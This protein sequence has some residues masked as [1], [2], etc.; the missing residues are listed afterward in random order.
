MITDLFLHLNKLVWGPGTLFLFAFVGIYITLK[1]DFFQF[2]SFPFVLRE[3]IG[4]VFK[5]KDIR[6]DDISPVE[7]VST[8]LAGTV[9]TG[10]ITGMAMA[11]RAGGPGVLFWMWIF[12]FF[13]MA[14]KFCEIF[15]SIKFREKEKDGKLIGGPMYYIEKGLKSKFLAAVF[16][17]F[18]LLCSFGIGN[19]TQS[20]AITSVFANGF[21]ID[22]NISGI[23]LSFIILIIIFGGIKRI[24]KVN[25]VLVPVMTSI[26]IITAIIILIVRFEN[27]PKTMNLI[28]DSAFS[29]RSTSYGILGYGFLK[30]I[31]FGISRSIFSN[32]AGL[33]S[34][35][36][37]HAVSG[38]KDPVKQGL[39]GIFEVA[40]TTLVICTLSGLVILTSDFWKS[41]SFSGSEIIISSFHSGIPI[42]GGVVVGITTVFFAFSSIL[43]WAYYGE[44]CILYLF[45][46]RKG[47][48]SAFRVV[49]IVFVFLAAVFDMEVVWSVSETLNG[50]MAIPNLIAVLLLTGKFSQECKEFIKKSKKC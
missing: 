32:E 41:S 21:K 13:G 7:A 43:G 44:V 29:L 3:T 4:K 14:I 6:G 34:A 26:Y 33:G 25:T 38:E 2:H 10:S 49:Y 12:S 47:F 5:K 42:F 11:I 50:L 20:N 8:A 16:A 27:L 18:A 45:R 39:W 22:S 37:A 24:C 9:G 48:V 17:S 36:I 35:P 30:G 31:H 23:L 28:I 46:K 19:I 1:L 15:L 40:F